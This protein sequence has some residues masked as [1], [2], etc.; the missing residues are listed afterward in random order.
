[1][2]AL[3]AP[4]ALAVLVLVVAL[5]ALLDPHTV[6]T[7]VPP[8]ATG[9]AEAGGRPVVRAG[10]AGLVTVWRK[11]HFWLVITVFIAIHM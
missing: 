1:M 11:R 3:A 2:A 5:G 9:T 4:S 10:Q 7:G 6:A 8:P